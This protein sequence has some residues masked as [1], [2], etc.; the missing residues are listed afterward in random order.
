MAAK[1][2]KGDELGYFAYGGSTVILLLPKDMKFCAEELLAEKSKDAVEVVVKV[3]RHVGTIKSE[4][5]AATATEPIPE[6]DT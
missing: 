6:P 1:I 4:P 2:K 5:V 3:G